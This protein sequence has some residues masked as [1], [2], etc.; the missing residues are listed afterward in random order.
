[1]KALSELIITRDL[2]DVRLK[3]QDAQN[4]DEEGETSS[5]TAFLQAPDR[6]SRGVNSRRHLGQRDAPAH[7]CEPQPLAECDG[8]SLGLGEQWTLRARHV[9]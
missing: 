7:A 5:Q 3:A 2:L 4:P 6:H 8:T 1:L 9:S